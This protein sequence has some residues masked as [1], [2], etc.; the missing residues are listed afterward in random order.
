MPKRAKPIEER[1]WYRVNKTATCWVWTGG[2]ISGYGAIS[3]GSKSAGTGLAHRI[4]WE[5][6]NGPIPDG[7]NVCHH[8]DN[9]PCVNPSHLF[10]GTLADN[11]R[12]MRD[13]GRGGMLRPDAHHGA[14]HWR[15]ELDPDRVLAIRARHAAG[16]TH[17]ATLA[18]Q[19]G[20][21][22]NTI[23]RIVT[24]KTWNYP[25]CFPP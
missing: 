15:A 5:M 8:C 22:S 4:S 10:L 14:N 12:D 21:S 19:Y 1:F 16:E 11:N 24:R 3:L 9:P 20:V 13:K 2:R 6:H 17:L 25:N 23:W 7:M 18:E